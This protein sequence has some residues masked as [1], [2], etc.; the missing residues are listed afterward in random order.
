MI[1]SGAEFDALAGTAAFDPNVFSLVGAISSA[2]SLTVFLKT[3]KAFAETRGSSGPRPVINYYGRETER[4]RAIAMDLRLGDL[5]NHVGHVP[6]TTLLDCCA[7]SAAIC[8]I[9]SQAVFHHKL[10]E[11]G[12]LG[13]PLIAFPPES[14]EARRL[15]A[16]HDLALINCHDQ[17]DL[18]AAFASA[19][20]TPTKALDGLQDRIGWPAM[21]RLLEAVF[22]DVVSRALKR[23]SHVQRKAATE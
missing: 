19:S 22:L 21:T 20:T 8:Y 10:F 12:A 6:R 14:E 16:L 7:N 15:S 4:V 18:L 13:R 11:M 1:Y 17:S 3:F 9:T 5:L 23:P 2:E